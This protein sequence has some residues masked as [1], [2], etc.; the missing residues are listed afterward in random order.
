LIDGKVIDITLKDIKGVNEIIAR[1][2]LTE[3]TPVGKM[4][5]EVVAAYN[6]TNGLLITEE[7]KKLAESIPRIN[8]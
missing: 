7:E 8:S 6:G 1:T 4:M 3:D 5:K 2:G